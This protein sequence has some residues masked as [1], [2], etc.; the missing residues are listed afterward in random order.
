VRC[1][2]SLFLA[3]PQINKSYLHQIT[4]GGLFAQM[5]EHPNF[6]LVELLR[7][8]SPR[9]PSTVEDWLFSRIERYC[10]GLILKQLQTFR[11]S[12]RQVEHPNALPCV[13]FCSLSWVLT[14]GQ[15]KRTGSESLS[16]FLC[17]DHEFIIIK[18]AVSSRAG[19]DRRNSDDLYEYQMIQGY[20][21]SRLE[22]GYGMVEWQTSK[23]VFSGIDGFSCFSMELLV[24]HLVRFATARIWDEKNFRSVFNV[25]ELDC[26][27]HAYI[28]A[29]AFRPLRDDV[30]L[31]WGE[32]P[33]SDA[34]TT[35]IIDSTKTKLPHRG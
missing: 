14:N 24:D 27:G 10:Q 8:I 18:R 21:E 11:M 25:S 31:G 35:A 19:S 12:L 28:P 4:S 2:T 34:L 22:R 30:C 3:S 9:L 20:M 15:G 26:T 1:F 5:H 23:N 6:S 29:F 7:K 16:G 17:K 32:R 33:L 13:I